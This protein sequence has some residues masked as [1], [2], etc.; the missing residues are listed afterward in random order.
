MQPEETHRPVLTVFEGQ[1]EPLEVPAQNIPTYFGADPKRWLAYTATAI[2][3][4]AR[5]AALSSLSAHAAQL[6]VSITGATARGLIDL[7][8][9]QSR[10][11]ATS[12]EYYEDAV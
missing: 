7:R 8:S 1:G 4:P 9:P 10:A 3:L 12:V 2:R 6:T 11:G 5:W